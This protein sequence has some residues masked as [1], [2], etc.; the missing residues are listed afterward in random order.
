[1]EKLLMAVFT[2]ID[3]TE[4]GSGGAASWT[5]SSI[6]STYDHLL[7]KASIRTVQ[8]SHY[9]NVRLDINSDTGA[10]Y[11]YM[12]AMGV[13]TTPTI[14]ANGS[15]GLTYFYSAFGNGSDTTADTFGSVQFWI[16][17]YANT[18]GY[19]Q[20]LVDSQSETK[21]L[22]A[23]DFMISASTGR[24]QS[25]SAINEIKL[26]HSTGNMLEYSTITLYGMT[27]NA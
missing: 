5:E 13:A 27:N 4:I 14:Y 12:R 20:I 24:W 2:V 26:Y 17:N 18:T 25:T 8:A 9:A 22:A 16:P 11:S 1:M 10:N 23:N 21:S 7:I 19:K 15:T 6:P 3:H